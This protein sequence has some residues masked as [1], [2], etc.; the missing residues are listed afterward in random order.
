M[1]LPKLNVPIYELVVPSTDKKIKYRPFLVK[2]EKVL[3]IAMESGEPE[4]MLRAV[5]DIVNECT[6]N[7]LKLGIMP[8]FD[9]EYIFLNIRA[10][11]VGEVSK[12]KVLCQDDGETYA[13]VEID[14]NEINVQV[15]KEHTNKIELTDET[16]VIMQYPTIDS[17]SADGIADINASNMLDVIVS[18]IAQ[19]YDKGGEEVYDAKDSTKKELVEFVEQMNTKQFAEVQKFYDTMPS[20]KHTITVKNPK[21]KVES[22]VTLTGLNDFFV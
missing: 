14:L 7:K 1:A 21:T 13:D 8:M 11:S 5:K 20:L 3:L 16:G 2:E 18:C 10:K 15:D 4:D 19:I 17:F 9:V 22:K 6:F 12:L